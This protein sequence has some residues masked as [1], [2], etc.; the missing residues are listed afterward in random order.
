MTK[1]FLTRGVAGIGK[2]SY[3]LKNAGTDVA[4]VE[5]DGYRKAGM[6]DEREITRQ[7]RGDILKYAAEGVEEIW[8][9]DTNLNPKY[10]FPML[11]FLRDAQLTYEV[12]DFR[13]ETALEAL[14]NMFTAIEQDRTRGRGAVG[15]TVIR[16]QFYRYVAPMFYLKPE[17]EGGSP[18]VVCDLDGTLADLNG[19][20]PYAT[21]KSILRDKVNSNVLD[22]LD[23]FIDKYDSTVVLLSGRKEDARPYT[24]QWLY[25]NNV[26]Y[27]KLHM[28]SS[29]DNRKDY[30]VK[31]ELFMQSGLDKEN[32]KAVVD[33]RQ[34]VV[35]L[36][37]TL[38]LPVMQVGLQPYF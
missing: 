14:T 19:R 8:V 36:W 20:S 3:V 12:I 6:T 5:R 10:Y 15:E 2:S 24:E 9:S 4:I 25:E 29:G 18:F 27:D 16:Q 13:G 38:G 26:R 22:L 1:V 33:D 23:L 35:D 17:A 30:V 37:R 32:I 28:R 21:N 31:Y 34:Q 11:D 7:Q